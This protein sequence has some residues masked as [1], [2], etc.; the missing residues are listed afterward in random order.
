MSFTSNGEGIIS[1]KMHSSISINH[2]IAPSRVLTKM[3]RTHS[4]ATLNAINNQRLYEPIPPLFE[5][6]VSGASN[7]YECDDLFNIMIAPT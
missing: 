1:Q 5:K 4:Q 3:A 2:S 6:E 7:D